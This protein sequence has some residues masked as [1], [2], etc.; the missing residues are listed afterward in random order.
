MSKRQLQLQKCKSS[1]VNN[2]NNINNANKNNKNNKNSKNKTKD[3][4][5]APR[6]TIM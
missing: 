3:P 2:I 4:C 5:N 1:N 6:P